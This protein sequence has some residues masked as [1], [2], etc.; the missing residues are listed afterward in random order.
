VG[1]SIRATSK[2]LNA[3]GVKISHEGLRRAVKSGRV[4]PESDGTLDPKKAKKQL[5]EN[6]HPGRGNGGGGNGDGGATHYQQART[7]RET[8]KA[9]IEELEY[10]KLA[11]ELIEVA[12]VKRITFE[13]S[14]RARDLLLSI[15]PRLAPVLAGVSDP[16][17][18]LRLIED[19]VNRVC[20][21]LADETR[22]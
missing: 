4:T 11:G 7:F 14:R 19:E 10:R 15:P 2:I 13:R 18:C 17:E 16:K 1:K 3:E 20:D 5:R 9:K 22:H 8:F 21:E 6:T 12:E